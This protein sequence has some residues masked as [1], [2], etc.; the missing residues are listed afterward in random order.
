MSVHPGYLCP[1]GIVPGDLRRVPHLVRHHVDLF[2]LLR[3]VTVGSKESLIPGSRLDRFSF[4]KVV[5]IARSSRS[6]SLGAY[7]ACVVA[8]KKGSVFL[9]LFNYLSCALI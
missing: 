1:D 8:W 6:V 9:C 4:D 3:G 5:V 7:R 2:Y